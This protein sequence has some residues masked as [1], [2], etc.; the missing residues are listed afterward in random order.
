MI[1]N[2]C[3]DCEE[4][5]HFKFEAKYER[6]QDEIIDDSELTITEFIA[7]YNGDIIKIMTCTECGYSYEEL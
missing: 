3:R 6:W 5:Q 2:Y 1:Y 7:R 4:E